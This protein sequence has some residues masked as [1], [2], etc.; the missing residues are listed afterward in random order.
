MYPPLGGSAGP[1]LV[2][3]ADASILE[4][5]EFALSYNGYARNGGKPLTLRPVVEPVF[6]QYRGT[7]TLPDDLH[8]LRSA[9]FWEQ[10]QNRI[11]EQN[12]NTSGTPAELYWRAL[13]AKIREL[14]GGEIEDPPD[15]PP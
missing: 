6:H 5:L 4:I 15:D 12:S 2:P 7:K 1:L 14:T 13:V 3:A 11:N 8:L 10:R 9:L